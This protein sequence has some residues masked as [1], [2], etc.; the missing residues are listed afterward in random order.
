MA[1]PRDNPEYGRVIVSGTELATAQWG[2]AVPRIVL[3]HDGLG[4]LGLWRDLPGRIARR[5]GATVLVYDRAGHGTSLPT[6]LGP[7]PLDWMSREAELLDQLLSQLGATDVLLVGHSDGASIALLHAATPGSS[8][9]GVVALAPHSYV[10]SR[11][12]DAIASM[13]RHPGPTVAALTPY[14]QDAA[15]IFDAW[16]GAW[17]SPEFVSWDIRDRLGEITVPTLVVQGSRD[18]YATDAMVRDTAEAIGAN[19][20]W[21]LLDGLG[22]LLHREDPDAVVN[23]IAHFA[24]AHLRSD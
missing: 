23:L 19:A 8:V 13:R 12:T 11:C 18:Q 7:W 22:H 2:T 16:S 5:T 3:L 1:G 14:H 15:A 20:N 21:R 9:T 6:P 4:S 17:T 24:A 10:E